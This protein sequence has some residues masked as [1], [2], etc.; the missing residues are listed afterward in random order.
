MRLLNRQMK[1]YL[2]P[3]GEAAVLN[4]G[5]FAFQRLGKGYFFSRSV[6]Q[7]LNLVVDHYAN[8]AFFDW[9]R[10]EYS[11]N[12]VH[13]DELLPGQLTDIVFSGI[14]LIQQLAENFNE[15]HP[16]ENAVFWLSC[17]EGGE[18]PSATFGFYV[19]RKGC[20]PILPEDEV[21]VSK[22]SSPLMMVLLP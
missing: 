9:S 12:K 16:E 18:M 10:Y 13:L 17:D 4:V 5:D 15:A 21:G 1:K 14:A 22:F 3:E 20:P 2:C 19:R 11:Q 8:D 6:S 7:N